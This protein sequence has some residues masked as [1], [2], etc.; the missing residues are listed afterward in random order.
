MKAIPMILAA[1]LANL[2]LCDAANADVGQCHVMCY[3]GLDGQ[4][5]APQQKELGGKIM[6]AHMSSGQSDFHIVFV[7]LISRMPEQP[8]ALYRIEDTALGAGEYPVHGYRL[9]APSVQ[10]MRYAVAE[11]EAAFKNSRVHQLKNGFRTK[12]PKTPL[13]KE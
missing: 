6:K 13:Y 4:L 8:D 12:S 2:A 9:T 1:V 10:G 5:D 3:C 7:C 11:V